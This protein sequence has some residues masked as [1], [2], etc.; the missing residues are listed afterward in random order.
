MKIEK[1]RGT[2]NEAAVGEKIGISN[3]KGLL[4]MKK[5][6]IVDD[7]YGIRVLLN[8]V[9]KKDGFEIFQS[10]NG[11]RALELVEEEN[12]DLMLLDIRIPGM[13]GLE[14]MKEMKKRGT[15]TGVK[16]ILMT[17][18]GEEQMML[19]AK[20]LGITDHCAKP[21]DISTIREKVKFHLET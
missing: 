10:A 13:D 16:I 5:I 21:F 19:E 17:A 15:D 3:S 9:L 20:E 4:E 12:P 18:F 11:E 14:I 2:F 8:E 7:Q 1:E 6:L